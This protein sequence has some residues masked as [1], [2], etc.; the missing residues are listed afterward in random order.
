MTFHINPNNT[1]F[2]R[3]ITKALTLLF[4]FLASPQLHAITFEGFVKDSVSGETLPFAG[5]GYKGTIYG[6][7]ADLQGF[8]RLTTDEKLSDKLEFSFV[9]YKDKVIDISKINHS[10]RINVLLAP[11]PSEE[12]GAVVVVAKK[13]RYKR[14]GNPAV[15][16][17]KQVIAHKDSNDIRTSDYYQVKRYEKTILGLN[18][19]AAPKD[20]AKRA[21]HR[22][23]YIYDYIDTSEVS[24]KTY[25]P[26]S[27]RENLSD[28]SFQRSPSRT[29]RTVTAQ[30]NKILM[31]VLSEDMINNVL[32]ES[33]TDV[34]I[35]DNN[36]D[37]FI[38]K[39]VSPIS[40]IAP[41]FY[42]FYISDTV[43]LEDNKR[44]VEMTFVPAN[45]SDMGFAGYLYITT[46]SSYAV[47]RLKMDIPRDIKLNIVEKLHIEQDFE[48][49]EEGKY[50]ISHETMISEVFLIDGLSG[51]YAKRDAYFTG[52][53]WKD[54]D[55]TIF[56][57][58]ENIYFAKNSSI[59]EDSFWVAQRPTALTENESKIDSL[60]HRL[61]QST[62]FNVSEY[63]IRTAIEGYMTIGKHG[64]FDYGRVMSTYSRNDLEG[65]RFRIGGRTTPALNDRLFFDGFLAYGTKDEQFKYSGELEYSFRD[66]KF[67]KMDFP[68][69][70]ISV[71]YTYDWDIPSERF[72]GEYNSSFVHSFKREKITQFAYVRSQKASYLNEKG[73]GFSYGF[74]LKHQEEKPAGDFDHYVSNATQSQI[75]SIELSTFGIELSYKPGVR[76]YQNKSTRY[77]MNKQIPQFSL[78]HQTAF[79]N[80]LGS[81]FDYNK[82]EAT[83]RQRFDI[84]PLGHFNVAVKGGK[85]WNQVPYP[86]LFIPAANL[87]YIISEETF[88]LMNNMEFLTDQYASLDV[89][90][91]MD[92]FLLG[93]IPGLRRLHWKEVFRFKAM[94]GGLTDKNDPA[95]NLD[96]DDLFVFPV[97]K[98]G[99]TTSYEMDG[100]PYMEV[101]VGL[102]N[103]FKLFKFEVVRRLNYLDNYDA[104]K[105]GFCVG[106]GLYM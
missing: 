38:T 5:V 18:D 6:T 56:N 15:D 79:D 22:W 101:G 20:S 87:S 105:W 57:R 74:S 35:Y 31:N 2:F 59:K 89:C 95:K 7:E 76:Y 94:Y 16:L 88:W 10:K 36:V 47:K 78:S 11:E 80:V 97:N 33:F 13:D 30:N 44:Y 104:S 17:I 86:T 43:T 68:R 1:R 9:G 12:L 46:D 25:L 62:F 55:K 49:T 72:L 77:I 92:G 52:Y 65:H 29:K 41:V 84:T 99:I 81:Q 45:T 34:Q 75:P 40:S 37:V 24:G 50:A 100:A 48:K 60:T 90:Y 69:H 53:K 61:D 3:S 8:Y 103:I 19:F 39:F 83:Y 51:G 73:N 93:R 58:E 42:H 32:N 28:I 91:N 102:H 66:K 96:N 26:I 67:S 27:V 82:T 71:N 54:V 63:L 23:N 98:K 106:M 21:K 4:L 64:Y 14:K 85:I 70:S